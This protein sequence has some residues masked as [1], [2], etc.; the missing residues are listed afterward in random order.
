MKLRIKGNALRLRLTQGDMS[1]LAEQGQ[2]QERTEFPGGV[3]LVYRLCSNKK[4]NDVSV[5]YSENLIEFQ[6]PEALAQRW[7]GTELVT[8]NATAAVPSG[9]LQVVLEKDYACLVPRAGEDESDNFP[10]PQAGQ[11]RC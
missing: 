5:S 3:A 9:V 2:V 11:A 1:A 8:V 6:I 7:S 10:H 4:I